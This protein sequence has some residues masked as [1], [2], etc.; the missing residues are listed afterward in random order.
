M[1]RFVDARDKR[2][3]LVILVVTG[4][5]IWQCIWQIQF[6][7]QLT[8]IVD[9]NA[10]FHFMNQ[11]E[12]YA[13]SLL[14]RGIFWIFF[15]GGFPFAWLDLLCLL[16]T[17]ALMPRLK[18]AAILSIVSYVGV[19]VV[20][21]IRGLSARTLATVVVSLRVLGGIS[22]VFSGFAAIFLAWKF[23]K[24]FLDYLDKI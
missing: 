5:W 2:L 23:I 7:W 24:T 11:M 4:Y 18:K 17:V 9:Q 16:L 6:F 12:P 20:I 13:A 15:H 1:D 3:N 14:V 21:L 19:M 22:L 10:L 8:R